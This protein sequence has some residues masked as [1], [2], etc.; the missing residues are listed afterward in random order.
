MFKTFRIR[1][2]RASRVFT[3][4]LAAGSIVLA[5]GVAAADEPAEVAAE[6]NEV[7]RCWSDEAEESGYACEPRLEEVDD[8]EAP[9]CWV[10]LNTC[11]WGDCSCPGCSDAECNSNCDS[12]YCKTCTTA[13]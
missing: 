1:P 6:A 4:L 12:L 3:V 13:C 7:I 10:T 11:T 8:L 9:R 2:S 5:G